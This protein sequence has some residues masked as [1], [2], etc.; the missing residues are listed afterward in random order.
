[1]PQGFE[2][3]YER[4]DPELTIGEFRERSIGEIRDA[5]QRLFPTLVLNSLGNPLSAGT[6]R[7]DKGDS[8]AFLYKNLSGGVW[9]WPT[10]LLSAPGCTSND[11]QVF[12]RA[13][14]K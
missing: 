8:K 7:F 12:H 11:R 10:R 1:M 9:A 4:A 14:S 3:V 2:D 5:M 6:F 13:S